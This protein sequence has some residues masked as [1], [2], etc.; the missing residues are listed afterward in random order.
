MRQTDCPPPRA[1]EVDRTQIRSKVGRRLGLPVILISAQPAT[2][3]LSWRLSWSNA[4]TCR[5]C[6]YP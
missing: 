2:A 3:S 1:D 4:V 6:G 5:S